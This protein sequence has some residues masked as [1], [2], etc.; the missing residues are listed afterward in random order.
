L[1]V[2]LTTCAESFCFLDPGPLAD[3]EL[4]LVAPAKRWV[5]PMLESVRHPL[6]QELSPKDAGMTHE[7]IERF[8]DMHPLGRQRPDPEK[9]LVAQYHFWMRLRAAGGYEPPVPMAG[10]LSLRISDS[11]N[12]RMYYGHVGYNVFPPARGRH[13]AERGCRLVLP[14]ARMHGFS[15]L[16]ITCNPEN[17]ASR[18]TCERLGASLIEMVDLPEDF[19]LYQRGERRK[20]RYRL[21]I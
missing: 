5:E 18:R 21:D 17:A 20:C 16:W 8:I 6:T 1:A 9:G 14:L 11:H 2:S 13:L 7:S 19:P 15:E 4:E 10:G 12:T 3:E